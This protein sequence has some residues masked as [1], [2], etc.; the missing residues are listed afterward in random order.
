MGQVNLLRSFG[1]EDYR[2]IWTQ[3]NT[4]L[5]VTAIR[6]SDA[7]AKYP[8]NWSDSDYMDRQIKELK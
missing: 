7:S 4:R 2:Q 3:L 8:Y 6:T 5:N 1:T